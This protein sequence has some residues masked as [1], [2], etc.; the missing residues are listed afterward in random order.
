MRGIVLAFTLVALPA[1]AQDDKAIDVPRLTCAQHR[2]L[3]KLNQQH[4]LKLKAILIFLR[5]FGEPRLTIPAEQLLAE[6]QQRVA[7]AKQHQREN[8]QGG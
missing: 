8:C 5:D 4:V 7:T 3:I 6:E 1:G 2:A